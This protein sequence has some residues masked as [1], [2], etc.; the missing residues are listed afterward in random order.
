MLIRLLL[1]LMP[2]ASA[3]EISF[4]NFLQTAWEKSPVI[5]GEV[6]QNAASN[7]FISSVRGKYLP[8]LSLDAIDSTGFPASNSALQVGGLMGSPFRSGL[9]G[10]V[11]LQQTLYDFGRIQSLLEHAKA[12]RSLARARLADDKFRFLSTIGQLYLTCARTRSLQREDVD[13]MSWAQI[14]LKETARFT[15]TGQ[16]SIVD[17]S[18][19]QTEVNSL[20]LELD[21]LHKFEQS[22]NEQMKLYGSNGDC[23]SLSESWEVKIPDALQVEEPS[24]L[25]AK[26]QIELAQSSYQEAKASQLPTVNVMGSAGGMEKTRLVDGQDYSAGI[27]LTFPIWNGGEDA[28]REEAYKTQADYQ[29][30][31]LKAA[32]LEYSTR[33]KNLQDELKRDREALKV[34][35]EDL[36]QVQKTI[37]L[38]SKRYHN[39]EGPLI[40][41]REAF[42][43]LRELGL[44]RLQVMSTLGNVSLQVG[45]LRTQ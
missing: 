21:Q 14:N 42:K 18:L 44:Q 2:A 28:R 36:E 13:L 20:Q 40:D 43:Q 45:M 9:A 29:S 41:V 37:K 27:G 35:D 33:L 5:K 32:Q 22:L 8:H 23:K 34:I 10:G 6:L 3:Q 16:R 19:V 38:A 30:E 15:K 7:E 1:I 25:L 11:V 12:E 24:L 26:A 4:V 39:L 31:N 17:N